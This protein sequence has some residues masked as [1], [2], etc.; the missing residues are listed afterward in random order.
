MVAYTAISVTE[1]DGKPLLG[2]ISWRANTFPKV[3]AGTAHVKDI[4][5]VDARFPS[6]DAAQASQMKEHARQLIQ[7]LPSRL[8]CPH[9]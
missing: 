1:K 9:D 5:M 7:P 4:Q 3:S 2:V 8:D 6:L